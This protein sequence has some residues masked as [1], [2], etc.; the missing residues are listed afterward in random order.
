MAVSES[1]LNHVEKTL[2]G[3]SPKEATPR[4]RELAAYYDVS[5]ATI[6][7][8]AGKRG[9]RFRKERSTKGQSKVTRDMCLG[10]STLLYASRRVSNKIPLPACDAKMILE[11]SGKQTGDVSTAWLLARLRQEKLSAKD[12][13]KPSPH[14][15][16][17]SDHPNHV[18]Q[19]DVTNCLQYF[20]D[21]KGMGER[22]TEMTLYPNKMV[23]TV[24]TIKKELLRYAYVDHC[25]GAFYFE[26]FYATGERATDGA[27][28][29]YRAMRPKDELI[30]QRWNGESWKKP[31][32]ILLEFPVSSDLRIRH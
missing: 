2:R 13:T 3:L 11:D 5:T 17:L 16:L 21:A 14:V 1:I 29:L 6:N 19:F 18:C 31:A 30:K 26:Y 15:R 25:S 4:I 28:F 23:K 8:W 9:I 12:L 22:D 32:L 24:K 20:L 7:R 27:D 10:V